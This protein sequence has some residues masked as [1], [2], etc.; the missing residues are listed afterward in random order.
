MSDD[1][2]TYDVVCYGTISVENVTRLPH[3]PT[4]RRDAL[5]P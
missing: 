4:P 2:E 5:P 3:L 1:T